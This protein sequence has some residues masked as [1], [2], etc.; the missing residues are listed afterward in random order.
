[1]AIIR[2]K[3]TTTTN[4]PTGLTFGE[5]AFIGRT[6]GAIANQVYIGDSDGNSIWVGARILNAPE[7]WSGVTAE[8]TVPTVQAVENRIIAGGGLTFSSNLQ[9]NIAAGKFFGKYTRGDTIPALGLTVKQVIEDALVERITPTV[10]LSFSDGATQIPWGQTTGINYTLSPQYTIRT[11]GATAAGSTLE[12]RRV[13]DST[14]NVYTGSGSFYD[15]TAPFNTNDQ[16]FTYTPSPSGITLN[17]LNAG[18]PDTRGF[19][20]RYTIHDTSGASGSVSATKSVVSTKS[21]NGLSIT[22]TNTTVASPETNTARE[23]GRVQS[24]LNGTLSRASVYNPITEWKLQ[25][26]ENGGAWGDVNTFQVVSNPWNTGTIT[27]GPISHTPTNTINSVEYRVVLKDPYDTSGNIAAN[28]TATVNFY[29]KLFYGPTASQPTTAAQVRTMPLQL[30]AHSYSN[31]FTFGTGVTFQN[32]V[33]AL[34]T[35][36]DVSAQ[37]NK[38]ALDASPGFV[39][40]GTLTSATDAAGNSKAY[41]V[42]QLTTGTTFPNADGQ[43]AGTGNVFEITTTGTVA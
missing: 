27:I 21:A 16:S 32:F 19:E 20:Y 1:M 30:M 3:R 25:F 35:N 2:I 24:D 33:V 31:P 41:N 38:S 17:P 36:I 5:M 14:W 42:W 22:A 13:G 7:F 34:P 39:K 15:T 29:Y 8:T 26:R 11:V 4:T 10:A 40:S 23:K 28:G 12:W 18:Q 6:G 9:V 37:K 43:P